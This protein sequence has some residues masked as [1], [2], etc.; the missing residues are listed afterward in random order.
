MFMYISLALVAIT[1]LFVLINVLK[2]LIRGIKKTIGTL[3]AIVLSAVI[4][5][6][7]TAVICTPGSSLMAIVV[8]AI[9]GAVGE[10][11]LGEIFEI[12]AIGDMLNYYIAMIAA[13]FVFL[14]IY[15]VL[16]LIIGIIVGIVVRFIPP[17]QKPRAV[18]HR[19]G[20]VGVG[21]VCGILVSAILLMPIVGVIN[22]A[23][24]VGQSDAFATEDGNEIS[25][26]FKDA[27][28]DK[29][30]GVYSASCGW[31]F[32]SLA[33]A[34]YNG[35]RIYLKDDVTVILAVV[36][37]VMALS[38]DASSF[39]DEQI[40]TLDSIIDNLDRSALLKNTVAGVLS[41]MASSWV[42][43]ESFMGV[44]SIDAGELLNPVI[45]S[46]L[47]I[48][49][50]S[51]ETNIV[52]DMRT[53]VDIMGVFVKHDMLSD[54]GQSDNMLKK[55]AGEGVIAELISVTNHNPRMSA[56][57]D[58]ITQLSVRALTS[59]IG[60]PASADERY[61]LLMGEIADVLNDSIYMSDEERFAYVE[62]NVADA[63][64][65]YGVEVHG[66]TAEYIAASVVGDLGNTNNL[67]GS[68]VQ[69]FFMIYAVAN[70]TPSSS[71]ALEYDFLSDDE[72]KIVCN[73]DGT[74]SIGGTVL[75]NYSSDNYG[76]SYAYTMG[77]EHVNIDDAATLYSAESMKSSLITLDDI[78]N[79]LK[80]YSDCSDPDVEAAKISE[81]L[82]MAVDIFSTDEDLDHKDML[83]KVGGLLD[84][85]HETEIFGEQVTADLLKAI[86]QSKDVRGNIGLSISEANTF[87][88]KLTETAKGE[89]SSYA[90]TTQA[91]SNTVDVIDKIKD[92]DIDR[93]ERVESTKQLLEDMSPQNAELLSTMTTPSMMIQYGSSEDKADVVSDSVATLLG[94]MAKYQPDSTTDE[95]Q[96]KHEAEADAV[97]SV[98]TLAMHGADSSSTSLF[99]NE[100]GEGKT[101]NT[102]EEFVNL[103]V[104]S[105]VVGETL[106]TTVYEE[107]NNENPFGITPTDQDREELNAELNN[108]YEL[109]KDNGDEN[110]EKK[111]NAVAIISGMEP[112]FE[113]DQ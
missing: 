20:G 76:T 86:F 48:L 112:I 69:E 107:G 94:N 49:A 59:V 53:L 80:K 113:I 96:V 45:N 52:E 13:P 105:E 39:G 108:Y 78:V 41:K 35:E 22:I 68:D 74:I 10:G 50:T 29:I 30:Y 16:S 65:T 84:M 99:S 18:I 54:P 34:N 70:G 90:S 1:V 40:A 14:A 12:D 19:L 93:E 47:R 82:S 44:E 58:E 3:V 104:N 27:S 43:G 66:H 89:D 64:D 24:S 33:S 109:N 8:D 98:L 31:M 57:S 46:I 42:S 73:P 85:M 88:D 23:V 95:G 111:L 25:A 102:A 5:A 37:N 9:Q 11:D 28:E 79:N 81:M 2:G 110:L 75:E 71:A 103:F 106:I 21:L 36:E 61:N 63:L 32:D 77:K 38:G 7:V 72:L 91:V 97:N 17:K 83:S 26:I 55:L 87:T 6:I 4:A 92:K 100:N 60:I 15:I 67:E 101:G 51:D 62:E 56:I